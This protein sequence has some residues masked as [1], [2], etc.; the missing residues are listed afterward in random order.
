MRLQVER[1]PLW[2]DRRDEHG[3]FDVIGDVHG[4]CDELEQVLGRLGYI[5]TLLESNDPDWGSRVFTHPEGRKVVFVGD[6]VDRG[7]RI[8]DSVRL[9]RNMVVHGS[10]LCVPGNH[11]MKLVRKLLGKNEAGSR[12][13]RDG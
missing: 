6:L 1:V 11:D 13:T 5:V 12:P 9:V 4:C 3:P 8:L 7:P 10:A 2:N